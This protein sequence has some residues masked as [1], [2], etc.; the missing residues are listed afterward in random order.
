[1]NLQGRCYIKQKPGERKYPL[2]VSGKKVAGLYA[3]KR[4]AYVG[5]CQML[6]RP[7]TPYNSAAED[8]FGRLK[9]EFFYYWDWSHT[10]HSEFMDQSNGYIM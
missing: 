6:I 5:L 3:E 1:M 7:C 9:H 8:I 4:G 10:I 2:K